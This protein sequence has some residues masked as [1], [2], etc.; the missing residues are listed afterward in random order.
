[1]KYDV[2]VIGAGVVGSLIARALS[3][4][5]LKLCL[6]DKDSDVSM[7]ASKANSGIVHAGYAT[8]PGSLKALLNVRGNEMMDKVASE[9]GVP[10]KRIG[11]LVVGFGDEDL[12]A[13][14]K[15][16][17]D[18]E[19]NGVP[20]LK[21]LDRA[22]ISEKEPKLSEKVTCALYAPTAGIICPYE[23]TIAAAENAA[24]NG[25]D[26]RLGSPVTSIKRTGDGFTVTAGKNTFETKYIINA[27]GVYS[28]AIAA[29]AG[30]TSLDV[31]PRKGEYMLL[32]KS[33]GTAVNHV[34]FQTPTKYGK[35]ILVT[36]TVDGNLL[37]G[38][39][40][41]DEKDKDDVSTTAE[42]L[43]VVATKALKSVPGLNL[44][45]V[46][47]SFAGLR[48]VPRNGD[49]TVECSKTVAGLIN[50]AGIE[51]PGLSA[52][53]AIAEYTVGL[54]KK[55]GAALTPKKDYDPIRKPIPRF[56]EMTDEE[57]AAKIKE[58]PLYGRIICR[59]ETVTEGEIVDAIH[60][61][62][63]ARD[64]DAIKRR[65]RQGMGRCQ[66]GFCI[67]RVMSIL[68]RELGLSEEEITKCGGDSKMLVG[69]TKQAD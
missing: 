60:R 52:S 25:A 63:G 59:C 8:K 35:G 12:P 47:N 66:G 51:S 55:A 18:G 26:V 34:I 14:E 50:V 62:V 33:Q 65:T 30:D 46:I 61:P 2:T 38:P 19:A 53:P 17:H 57:K 45:E 23:L 43:S 40:A 1:M 41:T 29:M 9:L 16:L 7:G 20:G 37:V 56:A 28:D 11:S 64:L 68:S 42:G 69:T 22:G 48:S 5:E 21:I 13:L 3:R 4:Y 39:T 49:F 24:A 10:F 32:D 58:N 6:V 31:F 67:P 15:L 27:A 44:R 54:L 36:P